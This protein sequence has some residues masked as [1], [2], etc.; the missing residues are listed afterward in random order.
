MAP[1]IISTHLVDALVLAE[2]VAVLLEAD[3]DAEMLEARGH[4]QLDRRAALAEEGR[5]DDLEE[6]HALLRGAGSPPLAR[7]VSTAA[8][9]LPRACLM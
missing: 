5:V 6:Q 9:A 2:V 1:V 7:S 4:R 8:A 3:G